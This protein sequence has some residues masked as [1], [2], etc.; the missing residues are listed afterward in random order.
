MEPRL[1]DKTKA[2]NFRSLGALPLLFFS[3]SYLDNWRNGDPA[4]I[5]WICHVSNLLLAVGI[6][7]N[8][9]Y[10]NRIAV[11]WIIPGFVIWLA[12]GAAMGTLSIIGGISHIGSLLIA[13]YVLRS[14]YIGKLV[15][16]HAFTFYLCL[17]LLSRFLTPQKLNVNL[18]HAVWPGWEGLFQEYYQYWIFTTVMIILGLWLLN[19]L[20]WRLFPDKPAPHSA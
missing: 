6:F 18:S 8:I 4:G 10:L 14:I 2:I 11:M 13:F 20:L 15:W 9:Q 1:Q 19:L 7:S 5:L 16:P 3:I 17:Q 12:N